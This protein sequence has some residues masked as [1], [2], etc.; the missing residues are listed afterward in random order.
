MPTISTN[1]FAELRLRRRCCGFAEGAA[2]SPK[3]LR[4]PPKVLGLRRRCCGFAEGAGAFAEGAAASPKVLG[5]S[6]K[7][8]R[9]ST[10]PR[11]PSP[12]L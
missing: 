1:G 7:V 4:L 2:A 5:T 10:E 11:G 12:D 3:V 8:L 9:P 6:P